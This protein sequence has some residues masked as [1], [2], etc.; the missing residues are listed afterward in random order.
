ME[1]G[2][3]NTVSR[4]LDLP[5]MEDN[6]KIRSVVKTKH[7]SYISMESLQRK[8]NVI[9]M[10]QHQSTHTALLLPPRHNSDVLIYDV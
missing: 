1:E 9:T 3:G 7:P 2:F 8:D 6:C 10:L 5:W 4:I